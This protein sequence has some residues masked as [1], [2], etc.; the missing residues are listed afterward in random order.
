MHTHEK[1]NKSKFS[2]QY[3]YNNAN[4]VFYVQTYIYKC[5][6]VP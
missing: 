5:N 6:Y 4:C 3:D 1:E 2:F